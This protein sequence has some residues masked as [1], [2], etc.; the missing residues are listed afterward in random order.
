MHLVGNHSDV[1]PWLQALDVFVLPSYANEGVP[2]ALMQAM[3]CGLPCV[4]T[5]IGAIPE[6][7][8]HD[9]T[10]WVVSAQDVLALKQSLGEL[11][12]DEPLRLRLG[13]LR[14]N[15]LRQPMAAP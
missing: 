5:N 3:A 8:R 15:M 12:A 1:V 10:V 14:G 13:P 2:Q 7:A 11:L 4:T 9:L 6:L